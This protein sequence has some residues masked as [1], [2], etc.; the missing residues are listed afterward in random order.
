V[1]HS[2]S[3]TKVRKPYD[4]FPL[5]PHA[6]GRWAKKV[7]GKTRFFGPTK[8][9]EDGQKA[10]ANWK[11]QQDDLRA[12][13]EPRAKD[14]G[15]LTLADLVNKFLA[16]KRIDQKSGKLS[17]RTYV[18]YTRTC[19]LL[20]ET[21]GRD[22][23]VSD[24]RPDDFERLYNRLTA[25]HGL[26]TI[27]REV[28]MVRSVFRYGAEADLLE[29]AVKFG[30][31]FKSPSKTDKRK[32]RGKNKREHGARL[33]TA[34]E[35][36]RLIDAAPAQLK[37]MI[38][39]GIN[40]G[41]GNSDLANLP[42]SALDLDGGWLDYSR[43]KTGIERRI[44]LWPE[45]VAALRAVIGKTVKA[46]DE[47]DADMVFLTRTG[48]RW[49]RYELIEKENDDG[50]LEVKGRADDAIAKAFAR[51]VRELGIYRRGLSFYTLRH[52]AETIGGGCRDQVGV[53]AILGHAD[54]SMAAEYREHVEDER[55]MAVTDHIRSWL[56]DEAHMC[57][58]PAE[59]K[60]APGT[61]L[62]VVG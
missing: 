58:A 27:G 44:P 5:Y 17:P 13:R 24:I 43:P 54:A 3:A 48:Q 25:K 55:L 18:E 49:V 31:R 16:G 52:N 50:K 56:F 8:G 35:I 14:A 22:R 21:F 61:R 40:G 57:A 53:D 20:I 10:L 41:L 62:R 45:T 15:G 7:R 59:S 46:K 30:P 33:F 51:L 37:S 60:P 23:L 34:E 19:G 32:L 42:R 1:S 4:D 6:T 26:T 47:A 36:R 11:E 12:G 29:K 39:L 2:N 9:D 38:Y 28:T